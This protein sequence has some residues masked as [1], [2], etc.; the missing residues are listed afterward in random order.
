MQYICL[1]GCGDHEIYSSPADET[2]VFFLTD[3]TGVV[4]NC[5]ETTLEELSGALTTAIKNLANLKGGEHLRFGF[6]VASN[7]EELLESINRAL[8]LAS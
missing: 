6:H 3:E 7:R 5:K 2:Q 1:S 8:R 4:W